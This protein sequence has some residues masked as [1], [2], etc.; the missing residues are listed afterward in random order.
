MYATQLLQFIFQH[1]LKLVLYVRLE[2]VSAVL[3]DVTLVNGYQHFG[4]QLL[5]SSG[6][7]F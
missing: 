5:P 7:S 6:W 1:F 2:I 3:W 4:R